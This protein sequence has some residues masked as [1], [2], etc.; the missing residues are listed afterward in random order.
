MGRDDF[1]SPQPL[2]VIMQSNPVLH[3]LPFGLS[4]GVEVAHVDEFEGHLIE[5]DVREETGKRG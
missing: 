3:E 1:P 4:R 5:W 2:P